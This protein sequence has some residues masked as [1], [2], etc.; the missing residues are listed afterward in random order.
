[1]VFEAQYIYVQLVVSPNI[2]HI[3]CRRGARSSSCPILTTVRSL[4]FYTPSWSSPEPD[5]SH[6]LRA[7]QALPDSKTEMKLP[8]RQFSN[9]PQTRST[10]GRD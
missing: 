4:N 2:N 1:M 10:K 6:I 3:K 5:L 8:F 7:L 9:R